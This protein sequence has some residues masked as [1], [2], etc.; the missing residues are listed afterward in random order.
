MLTEKHKN[1]TSQITFPT[2]SAIFPLGECRN[3]TD[4]SPEVFKSQMV[5]GKDNQSQRQR[6]FN[7]SLLQG[8]GYLKT[9]LPYPQRQPGHESSGVGAEETKIGQAMI[10]P[11]SQKQTVLIPGRS[12]FT[13][14][15]VFLK[16][17]NLRLT[18]KQL[19]NVPAILWGFVRSGICSFVGCM[20]GVLESSTNI[21]RE[22]HLKRII[23]YD[24][25]VACQFIIPVEGRGGNAE[26]RQTHG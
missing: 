5:L 11:H 26:G 4:K 2:C 24:I 14:T 10:G 19:T 21:S 8:L 12:F 23:D 22:K 1:V 16:G 25:P 13:F 9:H 15:A 7:A 3:V 18:L 20:L 6:E 17:R